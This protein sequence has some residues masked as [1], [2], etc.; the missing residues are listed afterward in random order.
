M[1]HNESLL[2]SYNNTWVIYVGQSQV[3]IEHY[4]VAHYRVRSA[5]VQ[6]FR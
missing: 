4:F 3:E 2:K 5:V 1:Q 6:Y